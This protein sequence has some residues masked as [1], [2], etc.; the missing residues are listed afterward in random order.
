MKIVDDKPVQKTASELSVTEKPL[1]QANNRA[2]DILFFAV[3]INEHRKIAN[4]EIAKETW[5]I[6]VTCHE[7][8]DVVKQ[9]KL[10]RLTTEFEIIIM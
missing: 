4:Y 9:S 5:D 7:G 10:Q 2:L 1:L 3:D 8:T 6:L